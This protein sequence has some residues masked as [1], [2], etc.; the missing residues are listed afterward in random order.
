MD[1]SK[2]PLLGI[3]LLMLLAEPCAASHIFMTNFTINGTPVAAG[4]AFT[5]PFINVNVGE[6]VTFAFDMYGASSN[7][8]LVFTKT[9]GTLDA[10]PTQMFSYDGSGTSASPVPFSYGILVDTPGTFVGTIDTDIGGSPNFTFPN[11][12]ST[13]DPRIPFQAQVH[14]ASSAVPEPASVLIWS[15]LGLGLVGFVGRRRMR[16]ITPEA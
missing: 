8:T 1:R 9:G 6:T 10:P 16:R 13:T 3:G 4:G 2:L 11:G 5:N 7:L 15:L 14:A 12:T